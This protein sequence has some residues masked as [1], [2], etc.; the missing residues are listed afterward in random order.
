M[1]KTQVYSPYKTESILARL[2]RK[3][4]KPLRLWFYNE[5]KLLCYVVA[6]PF[7][8]ANGFENVV[9]I[10]NAKIERCA[11]GFKIHFV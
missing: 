4:N 5:S 9:F 1:Y 2:A 6:K 7:E 3:N 11:Y 10:S 8:Y